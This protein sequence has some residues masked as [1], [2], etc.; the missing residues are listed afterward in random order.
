[1]PV[2]N[3]DHSA[4]DTPVQFRLGPLFQD[5]ENWR[6]S[7]PKIPS[8]SEAIRELIRL[9]LAGPSGHRYLVSEAHD[10]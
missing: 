10:Q 7:Q 3:T 6:R 5:V 1:M 9:A 8:R 2:I 4:A